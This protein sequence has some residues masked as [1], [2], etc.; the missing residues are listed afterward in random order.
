MKNSTRL[1]PTASMEYWH[2]SAKLDLPHNMVLVSAY[3]DVEHMV[4]VLD[5]STGAGKHVV[6]EDPVD[7]FPSKELRAKLL[8][9]A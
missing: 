4:M 7:S 1:P 2:I 9:L 5:I 8:V 6:L 3:H